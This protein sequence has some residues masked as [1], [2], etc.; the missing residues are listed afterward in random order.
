MLFCIMVCCVMFVFSILWF[1][2]KPEVFVIY[3]FLMK[4]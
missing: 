3:S 1:I 2:W 4:D